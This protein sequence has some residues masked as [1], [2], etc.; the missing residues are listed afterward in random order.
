MAVAVTMPMPR[1]ISIYVDL[2]P[3]L[4]RPMGTRAGV[5]ASSRA[6]GT[7]TVPDII[8]FGAVMDEDEEAECDRE[9]TI[10]AAEDHVQEVA[11]RHGK[12]PEGPRGQEQEK[13]EGRC[14][15]L[16]L[17]RVFVGQQCRINGNTRAASRTLAG[18][19]RGP[20][21]CPLMTVGGYVDGGQPLLLLGQ[22]LELVLLFRMPTQL[23]E[24]TEEVD[25][26]HQDD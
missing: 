4:S 22:P 2:G 16:S 1:C 23:D 6:T 8:T 17:E 25:A 5:C 10:K 11:L 9:G 20:R 14:S 18:P 7:P 24:G 15:Q 19:R 3:C 21:L 12:C 26:C 13:G